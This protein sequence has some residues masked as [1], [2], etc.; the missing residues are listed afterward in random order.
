MLKEL[1][2]ISIGLAGIL[3]VA[4]VITAGVYVPDSTSASQ[5]TSSPC[6]TT[7]QVNVKETLSVAI[8]TPSTWASGTPT[9]E[10]ASDSWS[11]DFLRN[12]VSL[13]VTS[14]NATGFTATMYA[15]S[16]SLTN[17]SKASVT[18]P[19]LTASQTRGSF[20][21]NHWGYSLNTTG[22]SAG[23][24]TY[25]A[26]IYNE[27]EAG[28][29]N[30]YYH[31]LATSA[32]P[33]TVLTG[34]G[35]TTGERDIYFGAKADL[36]QASGTYSGTVVISVVTGEVKDNNDSESTPTTPTNP[37]TPADDTAN[38]GIATYNSTAN[39]TVYTTTSGNTTTTTVSDGDNTS[40][41]ASPQGVSE[42]YSSNISSSSPL[43]I[44]LASAA[45][46]AAASGG[47]FFILAKRK[48][49]DDE[50]E[51]EV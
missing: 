45:A 22:D 47:I 41:Y 16:S 21:P 51:E 50:E 8:T 30:S 33:D 14:N 32:A 6:N 17:N 48:K 12:K 19:S 31:P 5:C 24:Y 4:T 13:S 40:S 28:N 27:T 3:S 34:V 46:V 37:A 9:Y 35:A 25:N 38:D 10:S 15:N 7:F 1:S 42:N 20:S 11:T 49:D 43:A 29:N 36:S 26:K 23:N 39:R 2:R 44:G 18:L